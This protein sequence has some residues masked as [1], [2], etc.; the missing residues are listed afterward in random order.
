MLR[1][2]RAGMGSQQKRQE[3]LV[4][5]IQKQDWGNGGCCE[6]IGSV[7]GSARG[8]KLGVVES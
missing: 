8:R 4:T 7:F 5:A 2:A 3:I 1:N 6:S